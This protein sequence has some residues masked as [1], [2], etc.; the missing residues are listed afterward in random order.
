MGA[1]AGEDLALVTGRGQVELAG[2]EHRRPYLRDSDVVVIGIREHDEYRMDLQAAGFAVR[3]VPQLRA[4]GPARTAQ[5]AR[6]QL[7]DCV[8]FWVHVDVD[9]LDPAVMPAVDAPDDGGIAHPELELLIAGLVSDT[10]CLG[11]ELT[12]FD[13]DH[14]PDGRYAAELVDMLVSALSARPS[15]PVPRTSPDTTA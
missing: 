12:V 1:A 7:T 6:E 14:D 13:P 5:W 2:I 4:E 15:I 9:V 10:S 8:G 11:M 3:A